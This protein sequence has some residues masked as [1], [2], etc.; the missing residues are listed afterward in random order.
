MTADEQEMRHFVANAKPCRYGKKA[1]LRYDPGCWEISCGDACKC[2]IWDGENSS[3]R[4]LLLEWAK[5][6]RKI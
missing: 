4:L 1:E 5:K 2:A 6:S 3:P